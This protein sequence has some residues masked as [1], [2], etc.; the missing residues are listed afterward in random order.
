MG[1]EKSRP[2]AG[3]GG[4]AG[5]VN[6]ADSE[7]SFQNNPNLRPKP[8]YYK[9]AS[10]CLLVTAINEAVRRGLFGFEDGP[11]TEIIFDFSV[12]RHNAVAY[13]S[14]SGPHG[15]AV[16]AVVEPTELG[17]QFVR[18]RV[19]GRPA[20]RGAAAASGLMIRHST[21]SWSLTDA[22]NC[23]GSHDAVAE[24]SEMSV[25]PEGFSVHDGRRS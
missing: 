15:V 7:L 13:L 17:R 20:T 9:I 21:G 5:I 16:R 10:R 22:G 25:E 14:T 23:R 3:P 11:V 4:A 8:G 12:G 2:P 1:S 24:L 19:T 6:F 18:S